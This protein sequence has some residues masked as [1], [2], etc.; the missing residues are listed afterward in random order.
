MEDDEYALYDLS[1]D[2][3]E[4]TN[5]V[6][7]RPEVATRLKMLLAEWQTEVDAEFPTNR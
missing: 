6:D 3:G 5:I 1:T 4:Q 2:I 7:D